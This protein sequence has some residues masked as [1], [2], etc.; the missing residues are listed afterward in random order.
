VRK[1]LEIAR[2]RWVVVAVS[3]AAIAFGIRDII[4]NSRWGVLGIGAGFCTL[5]LLYYAE[6]QRAGKGS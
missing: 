3:L 6:Q 4:D 1:V 2:R 5:A